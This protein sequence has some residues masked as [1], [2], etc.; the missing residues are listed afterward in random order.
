MSNEEEEEPSYHTEEGFV[1]HVQKHLTICE[2]AKGR[3]DKLEVSCHIMFILGDTSYEWHSDPSAKWIK[4]K[5]VVSDKLYSFLHYDQCTVKEA[6]NM[7]R[8]AKHFPFPYCSMMVTSRDNDCCSRKPA[9]GGMCTQHYKLHMLTH[10]RR[11]AM[12]LSLPP[13]S[14][15][16]LP[17][18][19]VQDI[20]IAYK[21]RYVT[22]TV[23][24]P[25]RPEEVW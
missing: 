22:N 20:A 4:F 21:E 7:Y 11:V 14:L 2:F 9:I 12:L 19:I 3:V 5:K 25:E 10:R 16:P 6:A 1:H 17:L 23:W 15:C 24:T 13:S 8:L 18:D